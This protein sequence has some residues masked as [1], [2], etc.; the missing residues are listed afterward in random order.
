MELPSSV[1]PPLWQRQQFSHA[2]GQR[3]RPPSTGEH[4][5]FLSQHQASTAKT[6]AATIDPEAHHLPATCRSLR[7]GRST[8]RRLGREWRGATRARAGG[9]S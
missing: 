6:A 5:L 7:G 1:T 3:H 8:L 9:H 4:P 2:G